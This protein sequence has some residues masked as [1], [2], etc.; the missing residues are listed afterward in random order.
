MCDI[1]C[2]HVVNLSSGKKSLSVLELMTHPRTVFISEGLLLAANFL[3]DMISLR[4]VSSKLSRGLDKVCIVCG[5]AAL[6][7]FTL[8][9]LS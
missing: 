6:T 5:M 2:D 3:S 8:S 4:G 7:H 9:F 1:S